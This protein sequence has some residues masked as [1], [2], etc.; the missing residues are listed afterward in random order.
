MFFSHLARILAV[1]G[2]IFGTLR[3]IIGVQIAQGTLSSDALTR[4][5]P[6]SSSSGEVI[7]KGVLVVLVSIALGTLA[8]ISFSIRR[9]SQKD[10][11]PT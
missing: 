3:I 6:D 7:D 9:R 10:I 2:I 11:Q 1:I 5:A 4:Y 8:E